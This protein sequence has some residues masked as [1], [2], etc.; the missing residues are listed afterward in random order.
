VTSALA[1]RLVRRAGASHPELD[2]LHDAVRPAKNAALF[3][4][5]ATCKV[6]ADN[7]RKVNDR[8][9]VSASPFDVMSLSQLLKV[10][11]RPISAGLFGKYTA[12]QPVGRPSWGIRLR[13]T[14]LSPT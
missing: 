3:K 7:Y 13:V 1:L 9:T 8:K 11:S 2:R 5:S 4:K 10:G 14:L 12:M 6:H